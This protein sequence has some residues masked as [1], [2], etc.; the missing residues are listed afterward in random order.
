L[1][2]E[3]GVRLQTFR[4]NAGGILDL[5][6]LDPEPVALDEGNLGA[7]GRDIDLEIEFEAEDLA[8]ETDR[9]V[10]IADAE[11]DMMDLEIGKQAARHGFLP[12]QSACF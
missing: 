12:A 9:L 1:R 10:E 6:Q 8:P 4:R 3:I 7:D 5:E 11:A 2:L